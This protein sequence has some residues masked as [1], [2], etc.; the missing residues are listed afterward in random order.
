MSN[1]ATPTTPPFTPAITPSTFQSAY[2][3]G[4]A[5]REQ[6]RLSRLNTLINDSCIAELQ[7]ASHPVQRIL[8]V[9]SGLGQ[10]TRALARTAGSRVIGVEYSAEQVTEALRQAREAGEEHLAEFRQG[11]AENLPLS[12]AERGSFD[13]VHTRFVLEH[14]QNPL[15]VVKEMVSAAKPGGRIVLSDDDHDVLRVWPEIPGL[16]PIW[17]AYQRTYD[18]L[19]CDP[20]IGRRLVSL[21]HEAGATPVRNSWVW[22]GSCSGDGLLPAYTDNL[23]GVIDTAK[24]RMI[25]SG[26]TSEAAILALVDAARAWAQRPDAAIWFAMAWAEGRRKA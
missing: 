23:L 24:E 22:F 16:A 6:S 7:L 18:R 10:L 8:D 26:M 3:H 11:A 1:G 4:T 9:G 14:V 25:G 20:I 13:L 15:A 5:P 21:L 17:A 12:A 19:G 2:V